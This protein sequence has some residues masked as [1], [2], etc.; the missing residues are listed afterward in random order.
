[1]SPSDP[2]R[3]VEIAGNRSQCYNM[4]YD[5][6]NVDVIKMPVIFFVC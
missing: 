5:A 1:M 4:L 6:D 2:E 3:G